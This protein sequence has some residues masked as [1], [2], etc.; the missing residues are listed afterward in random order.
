MHQNAQLKA[1]AAMRWVNTLVSSEVLFFTLVSSEV[2]IFT[3][4]LGEVLIFTLV[5]GEV[6]IFA[7]VLSELF[8]FTLVSSVVSGVCT[9]S[10]DLDLVVLLPRQILF[11]NNMFKYESD[12]AW[13]RNRFFG[14]MF[15]RFECS[16]DA[17]TR[18]ECS[19]DAF[20][21]FRV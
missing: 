5:S 9:P 18:F 11:N 3:L 4:V 1:L 20:H 10:S 12:A 17:L 19:S 13:W 21:S 2:L 6:L 7:L 15:T 8:I 14:Y 16:A